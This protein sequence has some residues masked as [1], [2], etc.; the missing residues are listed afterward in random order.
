MLHLESALQE[1][2]PGK[3]GHS[4]RSEFP[5][6]PLA[7]LEPDI[8]LKPELPDIPDADEA[9]LNP[10]AIELLDAPE[11]PGR[12]GLRFPPKIEHALSDRPVLL[13]QYAYISS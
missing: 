9:P 6:R 3:N 13:L 5:S 4:L 7:P 2:A 8:P 10:E 1:G 11:L 12:D